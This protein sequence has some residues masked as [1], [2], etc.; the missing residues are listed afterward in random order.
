MH[1]ALRPK[2]PSMHS[3][4]S[5]DLEH[6]PIGFYFPIELN[7]KKADHHAPYLQTLKARTPEYLSSPSIRS[8]TASITLSNAMFGSHVSQGPQL[9]P[10]KLSF[11]Y[12]DEYDEEKDITSPTAT[13]RNSD[14]LSFITLP[15]FVGHDRSH[16]A[17]STRLSA[18]PF[19]PRFS[20]SKRFTWWNHSDSTAVPPVPSIDPNMVPPPPGDASSHVASQKKQSTKPVYPKVLM[21]K[22]GFSRRGSLED[23]I[24]MDAPSNGEK[25]I[26]RTG[27]PPSHNT[28]PPEWETFLPISPPP[29]PSKSELTINTKFGNST[30][31]ASLTPSIH[32]RSFSESTVTHLE[33]QYAP[34]LNQTTELLY[35]QPAD[36]ILAMPDTQ[37]WFD[38]SSQ[39]TLTRSLTVSTVASYSAFPLPPAFPRMSTI[40][41]TSEERLG[42][43]SLTANT[44][45][46]RPLP[47]A[48]SSMAVGGSRDS[49]STGPSPSRSRSST[50]HSMSRALPVA[51][52]LLMHNPS[53]G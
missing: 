10:S 38:N 51:P 35:M 31:R 46:M 24:D 41:G 2:R 11:T 17:S 13:N 9:K 19:T 40:Y 50:I 25:P 18:V 16:S 43:S 39:M 52:M 7:K 12:E 53:S 1:S 28:D 4:E 34:S 5:F 26:E 21:Q 33:N 47:A 37:G 23:Y 3:E 44:S 48:P 8:K 32:G 29:P 36:R 45:T 30:T 42:S 27:Q 15:S 20:S 14:N 22:F 49:Y 6:S